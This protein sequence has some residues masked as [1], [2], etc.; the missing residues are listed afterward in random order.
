M[1]IAIG[2]CGLLRNEKQSINNLKKKN[3]FSK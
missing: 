1:K 3:R 2:L